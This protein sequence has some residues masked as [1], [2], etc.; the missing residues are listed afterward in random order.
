MPIFFFFWRLYVSLTLLK[1]IFKRKKGTCILFVFTGFDKKHCTERWLNE[2]LT[3]GDFDDI[4]EAITPKNLGQCAKNVLLKAFE[5][6]DFKL[7]PI[8]NK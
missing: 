6:G 7:M 4:A 2:K 8:L 5:V 1:F 3:S